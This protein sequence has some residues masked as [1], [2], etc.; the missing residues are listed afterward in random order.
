MNIIEQTFEPWRKAMNELI[1]AL[2]QEDRTFTAGEWDR[3]G[4]LSFSRNT[5]NSAWIRVIQRP[6]SQE[7]LQIIENSLQKSIAA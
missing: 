3:L 4:M 6:G 1:A 7:R 5:K 2:Q